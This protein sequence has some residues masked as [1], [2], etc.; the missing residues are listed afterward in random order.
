MAAKSSLTSKRRDC[1]RRSAYRVARCVNGLFLTLLCFLAAG[2]CSTFPSHAAAQSSPAS[3]QAAPWP[4]ADR[5]FRSDPLWLG[6]DGAFSVDL[7]RGRVLWLFG[8][9]FVATKPGQTRTQATFVHNSVAI[10]TGYN[11]ARAAMHFYSGHR[12]GKPASFVPEEGADWFWPMQGIRLG[13]RLLLFCMREARDL[14]KHS[15]GFQSVGWNAFLVDNPD[16]PPPQW[17]HH[18]LTGP[19]ANGKMLIGM[20]LLRQGD[21]LYAFDVNNGNGGN[22]DTYLLRWPVASAA[23]GRLTNP[24]WWCGTSE[25]WQSNPAHRQIV[26]PNAGNEFSVQRDPRG[27]YLEVSGRGFGASVIVVRHAPRI[28]GPWSPPQTIYRPPESNAPHAF[29]YGAKSHPEIQGADLIVTYVANG[30]NQRLATDM[31]IYFPRFV[32]LRLPITNP[33]PLTPDP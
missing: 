29:V 13:H 30:S 9:S 11:P 8:D 3:I 16:A 6:G 24:R 17:K 10:Q 21:Y 1:N 20:A 7:G 27:G 31:S 19:E 22:F 2:F 28:E 5:L 12:S 14:N 18:K 15:L 4:Q 26:I 23:E 32:R 25:G 33:Q